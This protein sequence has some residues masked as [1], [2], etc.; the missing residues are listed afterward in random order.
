MI[1]TD[2]KDYFGK[3][4]SW[5]YFKND[6]FLE[7]TLRHRLG[8]CREVYFCNISHYLGMARKEGIEIKV[9]FI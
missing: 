1:I 6:P 5:N 2:E 8:W 3:Y 9:R 4:I 7:E